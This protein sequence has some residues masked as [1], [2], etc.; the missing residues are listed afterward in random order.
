MDVYC[1]LIEEETIMMN[2]PYILLVDPLHTGL[3][4]IDY[5][6]ALGY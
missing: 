4:Y 6:K 2:N 5:V 3:A 1:K